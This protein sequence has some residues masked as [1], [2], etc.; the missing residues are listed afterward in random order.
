[1]RT[2]AG[3][4]AIAVIAAACADQTPA[5]LHSKSANGAVASPNATAT[6]DVAK[7]SGKPTDQV[8]FT[9]VQV[10]YSDL[11][12]VSAGQ[13]GGATVLCPAGSIPTGGGFDNSWAGPGAPMTVLLSRPNGP[14]NP[15]GWT[16]SVSNTSLGATDKTVRAWVFCA[17]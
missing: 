6:T 3:F 2:I 11:V 8:G 4:L 16:V 10:Y 15:A 13:V 7:A 17:S 9:K 1:M 12:T 14:V 5:G